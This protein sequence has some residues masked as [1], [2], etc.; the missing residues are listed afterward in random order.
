MRLGRRGLL[1]GVFALLLCRCA[2]SPAIHTPLSKVLLTPESEWPAARARL[3]CDSPAVL[4]LLDSSRIATK[5]RARVTDLISHALLY[6]TPYEEFRRSYPSLHKL[7]AKDIDAR[8][9]IANALPP[10]SSPG[11]SVPAWI[12]VTHDETTLIRARGLML[13]SQFHAVMALDAVAERQTDR[14]EL[15][16]GDDTGSETR[17]IRDFARLNPT[18]AMMFS[19]WN[20]ATRIVSDDLAEH[21]MNLAVRELCRYRL[22]YE[23][24]RQLPPPAAI[25]SDAW[26]RPIRVNGFRPGQDLVLWSTGANGKP[27]DRDD[28]IRYLKTCDSLPADEEAPIVWTAAGGGATV[29][30]PQKPSCKEL[31]TH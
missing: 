4:A 27:G 23:Q 13:I 16:V 10:R 26:N 2:S 30:P 29:V 28:I 18:F 31:P 8:R 22:D 21:R 11:L 19:Y 25:S 5:D 7:V 24:F 9:R 20:P 12:D 17:E 15:S 1:A 3:L 14:A 6:T